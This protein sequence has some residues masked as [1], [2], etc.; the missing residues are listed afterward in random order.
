MLLF[1]WQTHNYILLKSNNCPHFTFLIVSIHICEYSKWNDGTN[2]IRTN[3]HTGFWNL[4]AGLYVTASIVFTDLFFDLNSKG[5][6]LLT[7]LIALQ[8]IAYNP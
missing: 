3:S 7:K 5:L 4:V 8:S 2:I 6:S 1:I